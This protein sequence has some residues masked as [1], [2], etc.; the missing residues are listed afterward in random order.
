M[1]SAG[2]SRAEKSLLI[3]VDFL[4]VRFDFFAG[5]V[6][7]SYVRSVVLLLNLELF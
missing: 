2:D 5:R 1:M 7:R 4:M 3:S 6:C